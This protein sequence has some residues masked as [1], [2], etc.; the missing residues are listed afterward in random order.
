M[1]VVATNGR[2]CEVSPPLLRKT[3]RQNRRWPWVKETPKEVGERET[4]RKEIPLLHIPHHTVTD[5]MFPRHEPCHV[6]SYNDR[7]Q[8]ESSGQRREMTSPIENTHPSDIGLHN[9]ARKKKL[10]LFTI[11]RKY[12]STPHT[13]TCPP[14]AY[15]PQAANKR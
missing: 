6:I 14:C 1:R 4:D 9:P 2:F 15:A 12:Q 11:D 3:L 7:A 10:F 8:K 5:C 13:P